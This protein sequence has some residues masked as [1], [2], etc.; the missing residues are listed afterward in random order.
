MA[1]NY[2]PEE[3]EEKV[4]EMAKEVVEKIKKELAEIEIDY[5]LGLIE[6]DLKFYYQLKR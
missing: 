5:F 2:S 6:N 4:K 1:K 3:R